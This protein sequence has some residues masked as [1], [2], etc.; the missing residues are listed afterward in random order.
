[1]APMEFIFIVIE[2]ILIVLLIF[3]VL[4]TGITMIAYIRIRKIELQKL[5]EE[6]GSGKVQTLHPEREK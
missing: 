6:Q 3:T 5:K 1:M 4:L 2:C